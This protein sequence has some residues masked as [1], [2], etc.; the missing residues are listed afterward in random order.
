MSKVVLIPTRILVP[1]ILSLTVIGAFANREYVF[2]MGLALAFGVVGYIARKT[3]Y[4]VTAIL[5][6]VILGPLFETYLLRSLR[7]GQGDLM[8]LFSSTIGNVLWGM[9]VLSIVL[10]YLRT[11]YTRRGKL[12]AASSNS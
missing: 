1:L 7:I 6:G 3:K 4:H 8:I 5:I 9:V 11:L 2:D 10:P 12:A